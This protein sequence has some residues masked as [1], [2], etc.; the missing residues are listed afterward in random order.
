MTSSGLLGYLGYRAPEANTL[1]LGSGSM[2]SARKTVRIG[3]M[4]VVKGPRW[5]ANIRD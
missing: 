2:Y 4:Y 5:T 1:F 3:S